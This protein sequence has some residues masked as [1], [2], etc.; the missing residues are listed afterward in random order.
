MIIGVLRIM[1]YLDGRI[2]LWSKAVFLTKLVLCT[3]Y[4]NRR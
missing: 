3:Q 1:R 2:G 4:N